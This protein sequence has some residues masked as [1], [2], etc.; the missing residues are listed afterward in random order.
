MILQNGEQTK[1]NIFEYSDKVLYNICREVLEIII[2]ITL[3][4]HQRFIISNDIMKLKKY[5][6]N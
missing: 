1:G 2:F 6:R 3:Y 5:F 4:L